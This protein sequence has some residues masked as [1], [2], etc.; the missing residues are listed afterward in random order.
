MNE[1][2]HTQ[3]ATHTVSAIGN[4]TLYPKNYFEIFFAIFQLTIGMVWSC[5]YVYTLGI[6]SYVFTYQLCTHPNKYTHAHV[7]IPPTM[8]QSVSNGLI[9]IVS[10]RAY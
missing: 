8:Y 1:S 10:P 5:V 4:S 7:R 9:M 6:L 3:V 2:C